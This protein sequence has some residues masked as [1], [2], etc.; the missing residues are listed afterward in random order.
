MGASDDKNCEKFRLVWYVLPK[1]F[2]TKGKKGGEVSRA[3]LP[4]MEEMES[5]SHRNFFRLRGNHFTEQQN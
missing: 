4:P 1:E 3:P 5:I 2:L